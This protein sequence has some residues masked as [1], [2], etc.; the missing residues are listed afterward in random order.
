MGQ[1]DRA[2]LDLRIS[3]DETALGSYWGDRDPRVKTGVGDD[4]S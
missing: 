4:E 1:H 3:V 2:L